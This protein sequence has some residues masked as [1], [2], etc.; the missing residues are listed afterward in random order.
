VTL[1]KEQYEDRT[2]QKY[3]Y[4]ARNGNKQFLFETAYFTIEV[5]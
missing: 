5:K 4:M 2:L 1:I 3:F